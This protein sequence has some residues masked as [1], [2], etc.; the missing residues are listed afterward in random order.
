MSRSTTILLL[1]ALALFPTWGRAAEDSPAAVSEKPSAEALLQPA[2]DLWHRIK[3]YNGALQAFNKVVEVYPD[4]PTVLMKRAWFFEEMSEIVV[5]KDKEKFKSFARDDYL[6]VAR[7]D[8]DSK[9]AGV[10]RDM[11]VRLDGRELFPEK[12]STCPDEAVQAFWGAEA[13]FHSRHLK[14]AIAD[15]EV[16]CRICPDN[17]PMWVAH[18]DAFY[19]MEDYAKARSLFLKALEVDPWHK[20]AHRFLADT[21]A[22]L[23]NL[24]AAVHQAALAVIS[25]PMY[26]A[27]WTS[28]RELFAARG[29]ETWGRVY[30]EKVQVTRKPPGPDEK[31][32]V[33]IAIPTDDSAAQNSSTEEASESTEDEVATDSTVWVGYGMAKATLLAGSDV[34]TDEKGKV[35]TREI[36]PKRIG[37]F[38]MERKAVESALKMMRELSDDR[39]DAPFWGMMAR[40]KRERFLDEA[41]FLH[42]M[43]ESLVADYIAF[44]DKNS[45]RLLE[46]L[47]TV[48]APA[49]PKAAAPAT[50]ST[51]E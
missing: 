31:E 2:L 10:A 26:E 25:D 24:D 8:P 7:Q 37:P 19:V 36:D 39:G 50:E 21:E 3:D 34:E 20:A 15:Y 38:A 17:A 4:D 12:S 16:A 49:P 11:L 23:G 44:R 40:S 35:V 28:F 29:G 18:A 14:E 27:G 32:S 45:N 43:D 30:G 1:M 5:D 13:N 46:Y 48:V 9:I 47:E 33:H 41:I 6:T 42:M 22:K 51:G